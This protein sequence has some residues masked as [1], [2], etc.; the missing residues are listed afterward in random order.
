[1]AK[2]V[3]N[4]KLLLND[5]RAPP[6]SRHEPNE[7]HPLLAA[8]KLICS[9]FLFSLDGPNNVFGVEESQRVVY[10]ATNVAPLY[11]G[12]K[13]TEV[14][15]NWM[16]HCLQF[17]R[18][19]MMNEDVASLYSAMEELTSGE[20]PSAWKEPLRKGSYPLSSHWKGTYAFLDMPEIMKLRKLSADQA[21]DAYFCDKNVDE[22]KIQVSI[23]DRFPLPKPAIACPECSQRTFRPSKHTFNL[24]RRHSGFWFALFFADNM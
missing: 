10:M 3:L 12:P 15:M 20:K 16:L 17:F 14:N 8:V 21:A 4:S 7:V 23:L 22:G 6:A 13:L 1:L 5:R 9:Q 18:N 11:S 2:F 19:H 24:L